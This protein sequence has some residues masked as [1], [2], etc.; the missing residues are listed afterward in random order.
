M[1]NI[2][3]FSLDKQSS[4]TGKITED[5]VASSFFPSPSSGAVANLIDG[6]GFQFTEN[7][8]ITFD[9]FIDY[10]ASVSAEIADNDAFERLIRQSWGL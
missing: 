2:A 10:Y 4:G 9:E 6:L 1:V 7:G 8:M 5:A 3:F